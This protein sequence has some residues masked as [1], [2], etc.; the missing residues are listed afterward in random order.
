MQEIATLEFQDLESAD[1]GVA[2]C[3]ATSGMVGLALS[4]RTGSDVE[5]F[6]SPADCRKLL[7]ALSRALDVAE[8]QR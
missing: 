2:V 5:A 6:L 8:Q 7:D 3:R 1:K 4:L